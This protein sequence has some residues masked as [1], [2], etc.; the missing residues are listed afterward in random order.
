MVGIEQLKRII[1]ICMLDRVD[2]QSGLTEIAAPLLKAKGWSG[3]ASSIS[4][5]EPCVYFVY[6][7]KTDAL[8]LPKAA[9]SY[10][11]PYR[12]PK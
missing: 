3:C 8:D 9:R 11:E 4:A 10:D 2:M 1:K 7:Q 5:L 12:V 6:S